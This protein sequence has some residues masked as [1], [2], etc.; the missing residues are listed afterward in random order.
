MYFYKNCLD[1][2]ETINYNYSLLSQCS[3]VKNICVLIISILYVL[4]IYILKNILLFFHRYT[5]KIW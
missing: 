5:I 1:I 3:V 2:V 4:M